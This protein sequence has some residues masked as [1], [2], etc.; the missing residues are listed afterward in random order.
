[1]RIEYNGKI[2]SAISILVPHLKYYLKEK[3]I[4]YDPK[5]LTSQSLAALYAQHCKSSIPRIFLSVDSKLPDIPKG[6]KG[7]KA[8]GA[9]YQRCIEINAEAISEQVMNCLEEGQ[10]CPYEFFY[11]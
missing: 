7:R 6:R 2:P 4:H 3:N 1:M 5:L 10:H 8:D 9:V 11:S